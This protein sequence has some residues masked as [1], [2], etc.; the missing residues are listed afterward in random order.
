MKMEQML[1]RISQAEITNAAEWASF[2]DDV[3]AVAANELVNNSSLP[4]ELAARQLPDKISSAL[5]Q[6]RHSGVDAILRC[7]NDMTCLTHPFN[8]FASI[9]SMLKIH[10][11]PQTASA[12]KCTAKKYWDNVEQ[13]LV[14]ESNTPLKHFQASDWT[15]QRAV[16]GTIEEN[17]NA[18]QVD[19]DIQQEIRRVMASKKRTRRVKQA[20]GWSSLACGLYWLF[21]KPV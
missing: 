7:D 11:A 4:G 9:I 12:V 8:Y 6:I 17:Q 10:S 1:A 15:Q 16:E 18:T 3:A 21:S 13:Y 5:G 14:D 19:Q 2:C 20:L